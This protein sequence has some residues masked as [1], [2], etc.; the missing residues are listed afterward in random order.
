MPSGGHKV[1]MFGK[2][3]SVPNA[4]DARGQMGSNFDFKTPVNRVRHPHL[5]V[6]QYHWSAANPPLVAQSFWTLLLLPL[7]E[8]AK[9]K[10]PVEGF[11][12]VNS[13]TAC[14]SVPSYFVLP[15]HMGI[16]KFGITSCMMSPNSVCAV[17][18]KP[19]LVV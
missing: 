13:D 18:N 1:G 3:G 19:N 8:A 12:M 11:K 6:Q 14:I 2:L 16:C 7:D 9:A 17:M 10:L 5:L 4:S 15:W